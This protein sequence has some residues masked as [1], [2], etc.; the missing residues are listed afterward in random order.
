MG[1]GYY[2]ILPVIYSWIESFNVFKPVNKLESVGLQTLQNS[3][4]KLLF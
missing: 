1:F 2:W 3:R 4:A